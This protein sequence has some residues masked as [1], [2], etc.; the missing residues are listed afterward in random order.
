MEPSDNTVFRA[1]NTYF[2]VING[3]PE[4]PFTTEELKQHRIKSGDFVKTAEMDDYKEAHEIIELRQVLG[5]KQEALIPQ[6]FGSFDQRLMASA[7]DWF[8]VSGVC[9]VLAFIVSLFIS[10]A[11][12]R[13]IVVLSLFGV[14][15]LVK[16]IYHIIMESSAKQATY[17][18]QILKIKVCDMQG[19]RISLGLAAARNLAKLLSVLTFFVGYLFSF[20]TKQQQCLHDMI[21]GTLVMK[22]RLF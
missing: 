2:L 13:L 20:F 15:P 5:F 21:A 6:Y 14:I 18:K 1:V 11:A 19:Q 8:F 10:D 7:L 12:T 22:D 17:G 16:F 4:G 3:K 9:I